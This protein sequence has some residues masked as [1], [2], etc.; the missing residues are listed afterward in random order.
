MDA[1][2]LDDVDR[3]L[4]RGSVFRFQP[5]IEAL[6]VDEYARSRARMAPLWALIG[7]AMYLFQLNDDYNLT[8][9]ARLETYNTGAAYADLGAGLTP[10]TLPTQHVVTV[11]ANFGIGHNVVLKVDGQRVRPDTARDRYDIG[12]GWSF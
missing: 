2:T 5:A 8:P 1:V 6:F 10:E 11:G 7:L 4:E 12:I 9:F 3:Q